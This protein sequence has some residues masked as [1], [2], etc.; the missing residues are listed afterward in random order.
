MITPDVIIAVVGLLGIIV[1]SV[2]SY[3]KVN[4][5]K[6]ALKQTENELKIQQVALNF[7]QFM[8]EW[9]QTHEEI[10]HLMES[11]CID[12]FIILRAWNGRLSPRW[13][14]AVFQM[15]MGNQEPISYVHFELDTDYVERIKQISIQGTATFKVDELPDC[16]IKRVYQAEGVKS[17]TWSYIS[18]ESIPGTDCVA[19]TYCSF[20]THTDC[21]IDVNLE[22][23]ITIL[24]GRLKG[25]AM[26]FNGR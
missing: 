3:L 17:S 25:I 9:S 6:Q 18:E 16:A 4:K 11:S 13:T 10:A 2:F 22:T 15:R 12:R 1:T 20:S 5:S 24:I 7:G 8:E 26:S 23:K 21:E 19:H 14:T